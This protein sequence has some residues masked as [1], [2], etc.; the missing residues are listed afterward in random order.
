M[1]DPVLRPMLS[2]LARSWPWA[3]KWDQM[4]GPSPDWIP[5]WI[6]VWVATGLTVTLM[7]KVLET[8]TLG[9]E[10]ESFPSKPL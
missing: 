5:E 3:W 9:S 6:R 4:P 2:G 7:A 1:S 8:W 10:G